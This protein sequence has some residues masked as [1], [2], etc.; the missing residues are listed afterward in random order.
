MMTRGEDTHIRRRHA[1]ALWLRAPSTRDGRERSKVHTRFALTFGG[2]LLCV[3]VVPCRTEKEN[4][5]DPWLYFLESDL[6]D[7]GDQTVT[8]R[9]FF[10]I[11]VNGK[12]A[13]RIE[14]GREDCV[15]L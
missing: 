5:Y 10:D 12:E 6:P 4:V 11:D 15:S 8:S 1:L 7:P 14:M 3:C 2:G 9:V 13:G